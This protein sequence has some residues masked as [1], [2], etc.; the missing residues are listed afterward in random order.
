MPWYASCIAAGMQAGGF[1]KSICNH[2]AN[3]VSFQNPAGYDSGD[4]ADVS[5]AI[6]A[7]LLVLTQNTSGNSMGI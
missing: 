3:I 7:G 2:L 4:P 6:L 5:D 1:Y